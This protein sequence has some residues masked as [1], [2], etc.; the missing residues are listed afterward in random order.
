M[1]RKGIKVMADRGVEP[2]SLG[3]EPN[4]VTVFPIRYKCPMQS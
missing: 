1:T 2:L 3:Y 4:E